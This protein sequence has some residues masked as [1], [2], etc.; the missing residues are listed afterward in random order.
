MKRSAVL[1]GIMLMTIPTAA[2]AACP[3]GKVTCASWCQKYGGSTCMT[4]HP[5]SC[6]KK[7]NGAATCVKDGPRA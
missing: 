5:N 1:V 2:S 4:G 6:D 7:A 3:K